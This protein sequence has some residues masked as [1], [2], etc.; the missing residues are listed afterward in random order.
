M[1]GKCETFPCWQSR[2]GEGRELRSNDQEIVCG[3]FIFTQLPVIIVV[4]SLLPG[5]RLW[6]GEWRES[7]QRGQGGQRPRLRPGREKE[8]EAGQPQPGQGP[9]QQ[10]GGG[11]G[12]RPR[13]GQAH[14]EDAV[15]NLKHGT[16]MRL[17]SC[18][19]LA[20][21][22]RWVWLRMSSWCSSWCSAH[23]LPLTD[24][25]AQC[26]CQLRS[27]SAPGV[28][29]QSVAT[30]LWSQRNTVLCS[31]CSVPH[32]LNCVKLVCY[33]PG[34][35]LRSIIGTISGSHCVNTLTT[36]TGKKSDHFLKDNLE[37]IVTR[38]ADKI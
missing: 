19:S 30:A 8:A 23:V 37:E 11:L 4:H 31:Q 26:Q 10:G 3:Y 29:S 7:W 24:L 9:Q 32:I 17:R 16:V 18:C 13:G 12:L 25:S 20:Q 33:W 36:I 21:L 22:S 15:E 14:Q 38:T 5:I 34:S 1:A 6:P 27:P 2:G 28:Q 35:C